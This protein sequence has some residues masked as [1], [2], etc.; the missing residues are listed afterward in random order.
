MC[1]CSVIASGCVECSTSIS[2]FGWVLLANSRTFSA[3]HN[4][5]VGQLWM[6]CNEPSHASIQM[7]NKTLTQCHVVAVKHKRKCGALG[8]LTREMY[9]HRG[10]SVRFSFGLDTFWKGWQGHEAIRQTTNKTTINCLCFT[11]TNEIFVIWPINNWTVMNINVACASV[12]ILLPYSMPL[13]Q[14]FLSFTCELLPHWIS[15]TFIFNFKAP[16]F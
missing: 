12:W 7:L 9:L 14:L 1:V 15:I 3:I 4:P 2:Q 10:K 8:T 5:I 6:Q 16:N 13:E 11:K